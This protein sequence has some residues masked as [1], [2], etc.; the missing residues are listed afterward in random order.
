[1]WFFDIIISS[2]MEKIVKK[3]DIAGLIRAL[4]YDSFLARDSSKKQRI[5]A[6][7]VLGDLKDF[8]AIYP[9][10]ECLKDINPD[11]RIAAI[12]ALKEFKDPKALQPIIELLNDNDSDVRIAAIEALK[13]FKDPKSLQPLNERLS[14]SDSC[15]RIEATISPRNSRNG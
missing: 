3:R 8:Q 11:V 14:Y 10:I 1:M 6:I 4:K 9:I 15:V 12:Y 13:E 5:Q 7:R 2:N